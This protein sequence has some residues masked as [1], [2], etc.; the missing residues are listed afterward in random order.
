[1]RPNFQE[2]PT[3]YIHT[4]S[5]LPFKFQLNGWKT[6]LPFWGFVWRLIIVMVRCLPFSL[7]S[8]ITDCK[9]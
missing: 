5:I 3:V 7:E 4:R 2:R 6:L 1:M 9:S 8:H